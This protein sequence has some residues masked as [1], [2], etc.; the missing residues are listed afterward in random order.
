MCKMMQT[1][2]VYIFARCQ[3]QVHL[4]VSTK[5]IKV[6]TIQYAL[7]HNVGCDIKKSPRLSVLSD[8]PGEFKKNK[9]GIHGQ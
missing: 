6:V 1:L 9:H 3:K 5:C 4:C 2:C 8:A 7:S